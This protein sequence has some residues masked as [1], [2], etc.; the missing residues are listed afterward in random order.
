MHVRLSPRPSV[1]PFLSLL[2]VIVTGCSGL[3]SGTQY[4]AKPGATG[5]ANRPAPPAPPP[6]PT[7]PQTFDGYK[8]LS[9]PV[10]LKPE[11]AAQLTDVLTDRF[12]FK[13]S[14]GG[15]DCPFKPLVGFR[16]VA[17]SPVDVIVSF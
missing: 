3:P 12:T 14:L 5:E 17:D 6:G 2:V 1:V 9:G 11:T 15:S 13:T 7:E 4:A 16:Y 10:T 8:V